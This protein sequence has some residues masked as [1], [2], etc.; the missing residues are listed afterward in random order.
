MF[1]RKRILLLSCSVILLCCCLVVGG[2]YGLFTEQVSVTNHLSAGNLDVQL[3]RQTWSYTYLDSTGV[4]KTMTPDNNTPGYNDY[5]TNKT[6]N[7]FGIPE[8]SSGVQ[9]VKVVPGS[10][11]ES[12]L[13]LTNHGSVA[14]DYSIFV[15]L[16]NRNGSD[17]AAD[18]AFRE[19]L[20]VSVYEVNNGTVATTP[21]KT[22]MLDELVDAGTGMRFT[23]GLLLANDDGNGDNNPSIEF[24]VTIEFVDNNNIN[25]DA[26]S[27]IAYFDLYIEAIQDKDGNAPA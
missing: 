15:V 21:A 26:Q 22:A 16:D 4:M 23:D 12:Q 7:L 13:K 25:N 17:P 19:Q 2:T 6:A 11:F 9:T 14:V 20:R 10:K 8:D 18:Q 5:D 3:E 1:K 24:V 27:A